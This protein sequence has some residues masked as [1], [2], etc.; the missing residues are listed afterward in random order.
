M[1]MNFRYRPCRKDFKREKRAAH[2]DTG[3]SDL[4]LAQSP[5]GVRKIYKLIANTAC[6]LRYS[7]NDSE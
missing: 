3:L 5:S 2:A 4:M 1:E 6:G 7:I